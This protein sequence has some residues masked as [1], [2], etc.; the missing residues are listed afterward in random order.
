MPIIPA[1]NQTEVK[2]GILIDLTVNGTTYYLANTYAPVT[3]AGNSYQGL[4]HFLGLTD[5]QDDLK[6]AN[7]TIQVSLS[8]IPNGTGESEPNYITLVLGNPVKGSQIKIY[9]AFFN[10]VNNQLITDQV[11]LRFNG[12]ISNYTIV[13]TVDEMG[14]SATNSVVAQCSSINAVLERQIAGRRTNGVDQRKFYSSDISMDKVLEISNRVFDFGK[15]YS[16]SSNTGGRGGF[17]DTPD[18]VQN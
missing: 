16:P 2:H 9:R 3:W 8:G 14:K 1:L 10:V 12:Y 6:A 15:P 7:N 18:V 4:G 11:W 13:D 5:V 17:K